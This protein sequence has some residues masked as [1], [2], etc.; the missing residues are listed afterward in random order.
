VFVISDGH[1]GR[2]ASEWFTARAPAIVARSISVALALDPHNHGS[3]L[4][5]PA[6]RD[7]V[8]RCVRDA[9]MKL[10]KDFCKL[11]QEQHRQNT[12]SKA[13]EFR[14]TVNDSKPSRSGSPATPRKKGGQRTFGGT[15]AATAQDPPDDGC[16]VAIVS[17]IGGRWLL[18]AHV[19]DSR[20]SAGTFTPPSQPISDIH[21]SLYFPSIKQASTPTRSK[22]HNIPASEPRLAEY[23]QMDAIFT[24]QDHTVSHSRKALVNKKGGAVWREGKSQPA[25]TVLDVLLNDDQFHE[26]HHGVDPISCPHIQQL[27]NARV[28][29]PDNFS[30]DLGLRPKSLGMSDAM[31]DILMKLEPPI[32]EGR[33]DIHIK[34]LDLESDHIIVMASD[35]VWGSLQ[36]SCDAKSDS[37]VVL[38]H[39]ASLIT[40]TSSSL[41]PVPIGGQSFTTNFEEITARPRRSN[42]SGKSN[43]NGP[44]TFRDNTTGNTNQALLDEMSLIT[45]SAK[46]SQLGTFHSP[47]HRGFGSSPGCVAASE[48][49]CYRHIGVWSH[50]F[51]QNDKAVDDACAIVIHLEKRQADVYSDSATI[52]NTSTQTSTNISS[53][54]KSKPAIPKASILIVPDSCPTDK[55]DISPELINENEGPFVFES[56]NLDES[57][58]N[59]S[60]LNTPT[61]K[62]VDGEQVM[63][64]PETPRTP[65]PRNSLSSQRCSYSRHFSNT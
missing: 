30:N 14:R 4:D 43:T 26:E 5:S 54:R 6:A 58:C 61:G 47:L 64:I 27:A 21:P 65:T 55:D 17:I 15:L 41:H 7:A 53:R 31:G 45:N 22:T 49:L 62:D 38:R 28:Y 25:I 35:G 29:R 40:S 63:V 1:G 23:R 34:P 50:L 16:T 60:V 9:L 8:A 36:G 46:V 11:R 59:T 52:S 56:P 24:T 33:P 39:C 57:F 19:G 48:A 51:R 12:K 44:C 13:E 3:A 18:T 37:E 2:A 42:R 20:V 32:F 10:D